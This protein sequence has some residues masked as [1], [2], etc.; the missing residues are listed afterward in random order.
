M[1]YYFCSIPQNIALMTKDKYAI[2]TFVETGT[3]I[4]KTSQWAAKHFNH[5]YTIESLDKYFEIAQLHLINLPNVTMYYGD[6]RSVIPELLDDLP[7]RTM[8]YLD[9]HWSRGAQY[10]RPLIDSTA[11]EEIQLINEW[12]NNQHVIMVDDAH[13][14][15]TERWPGKIEMVSALENNG[16][17]NV[18]ELLDVLIAVPRR[19]NGSL[20]LGYVSPN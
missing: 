6:S 15:G 1:S 14:F 2:D 18:R 8:F 13:R 4:G 7:P 19:D 11:L 20:K 16:Q 3:Y 10:G 9:A 5:V 12:G 17:R